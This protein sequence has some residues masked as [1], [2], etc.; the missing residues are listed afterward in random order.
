MLLGFDAAGKTVLLDRA[1]YVE[2][3]ALGRGYWTL[4]SSNAVL[5]ANG[6]AISYATL[7]QVLGQRVAG[8]AHWQLEQTWSPYT[9]GSAV[10]DNAL[11]GKCAA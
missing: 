3:A 9:R 4:K 6:N 8:G 5:D 7:E 1:V 10:N 11:A 2:D